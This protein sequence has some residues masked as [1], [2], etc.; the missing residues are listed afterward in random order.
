MK[1]LLI[2]LLL[3]L[4]PLL[5]AEEAGDDSNTELSHNGYAEVPAGFIFEDA[6]EVVV[7][8]RLLLYIVKYLPF[9]EMTPFIFRGSFSTSRWPRNLN[10]GLRY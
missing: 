8:F 7:S 1:Y 5:P 9:R 2:L 10:M 4:L 6:G 3:L